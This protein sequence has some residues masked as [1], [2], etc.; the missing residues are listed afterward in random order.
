MDVRLF[1]VSG[2]AAAKD[3]SVVC[4]R[5]RGAVRKLEVDER[6]DLAGV[7]LFKCCRRYDGCFS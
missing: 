7:Y 4:K 1:H 6:S 2:A 3:L 5:V